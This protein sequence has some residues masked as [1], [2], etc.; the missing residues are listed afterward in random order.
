[1]EDGKAVVASPTLW[2][3]G[4]VIFCHQVVWRRIKNLQRELVT[5]FPAYENVSSRKRLFSANNSVADEICNLMSLPVEERNETTVKVRFVNFFFKICSLW[6][7]GEINIDPKTWS[8]IITNC[9]ASLF[10][11]LMSALAKM[12]FVSRFAPVK[13]CHLN[14]NKGWSQAYLTLRDQVKLI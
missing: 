5:S 3:K 6:L 11:S 14:E 2:R 13:V 8:A 9:V 4:P 12:F 1:M 10:C 7:S